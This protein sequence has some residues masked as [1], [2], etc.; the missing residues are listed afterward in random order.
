M[1]YNRKR[2]EA[3]YTEYS[4]M[5]AMGLY[6]LSRRATGKDDYF[7]G[8]GFVESGKRKPK[9]QELIKLNEL[10]NLDEK[11]RVR[12][13]KIKYT[14]VLFNKTDTPYDVWLTPH[15]E[16]HRLG[17]PTQKPVDLMKRMILG[18]TNEGDVVLD[19]FMG[20]GTTGVACVETG[21]KFIGFEIDKRYFE[22]AK[23]RLN[24]V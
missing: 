15:A 10:L 7:G 20:S 14:H 18:S 5:G 2:K 13:K 1:A 11:Y 3:G 23:K 22:I 19:P 4:L 21:R 24:L 12:E 9:L 16:R 8:A 17:H 6:K